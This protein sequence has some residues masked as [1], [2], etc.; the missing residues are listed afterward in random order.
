[1]MN[2]DA[3]SPEAHHTSLKTRMRIARLRR[4]I[5]NRPV[6]FIVGLEDDQ[7]P[8]YRAVNE[9]QLAEERRT[10]Y[11]GMTRAKDRLFLFAA[12]QRDSR[13][14]RRSRFVDPLIGRVITPVAGRQ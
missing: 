7:F 8:L 6:V 14:K 4:A 5:A 12:R 10:L 9:D 2:Q 3:S 13:A 11:V 1:M